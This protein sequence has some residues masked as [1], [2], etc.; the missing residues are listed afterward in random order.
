MAGYSPVAAVRR[1]LQAAVILWACLP[2]EAVAITL[3]GR[4]ALW[5]V[6][7]SLC[8]PMDETLGLPL[9][10]LKVDRKRG[11]VVIR[12]PGDETRIIIVPTTR[13]AGIESPILLRDGTPN[14]WSLA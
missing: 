14:F 2:Q 9:P 4:D 5:R 11:F 1:I 3:G 12:A 10:C 8:L 13:I 7:E 6:V